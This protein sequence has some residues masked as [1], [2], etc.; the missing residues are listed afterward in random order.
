MKATNKSERSNILIRLVDIIKESGGT[1]VRYDRS[2]RAW[3]DIGGANAIRRVF[4]VINYRVHRSADIASVENKDSEELISTAQ[5]DLL[6][7]SINSKSDCLRPQI[8][9]PKKRKR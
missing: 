1:F 6:G 4:H 7:S 9:S 8:T 2:N 5:N 3:Y